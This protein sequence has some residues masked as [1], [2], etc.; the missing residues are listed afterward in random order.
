VRKLPVIN[1]QAPEDDLA[2]S[3]PRSH[4]VAITAVLTV[5]TWLPLAFVTVPLGAALAS[6]SSVDAT[7]S[8]RGAEFPVAPGPLFALLA[9]ALP[10]LSYA[11]AAA[12]SGALTGRFG[13]RSKPGDAALGA[14]LASFVL[15]LVL[16]LTPHSVKL[17]A[18]CAFFVLA[19][20]GAPAA[21]L[22]FRFG[23]RKRP[24]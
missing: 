20:A 5:T 23:A 16:F 18:V 21:R 11:V 1:S 4:W 15:A 2:A 9:S 6:F 3:R 24:S 13:P 7:H 22:G 19:A 8:D 10:V 14:V 12:A 17:V